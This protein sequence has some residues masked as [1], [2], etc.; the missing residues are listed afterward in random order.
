MEQDSIVIG[1]DLGTTNSCVGVWLKGRVEIVP[2]DQGSRTTPSCVAFT[3]SER[4]IGEGA[5]HQ[6]ATNA[7]NTVFGEYSSVC[8][9][10]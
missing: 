5:N 7:S 4:L 9:S 6:V 2:S 1:I 3:D 8:P 10:I